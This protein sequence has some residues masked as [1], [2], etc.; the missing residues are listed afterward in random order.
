VRSPDADVP[1]LI[2]GG[3]PVGMVA[4]ILLAQQ[5]IANRVVERR[6]EPDGAPAAHVV[7]A[8]TFEILR[9]A[10]V[11]AAAIDAACKDPADAGFVRWVT[12]LAGDELGCLPF[13]R[14]SDAELAV[15][16]TPLRNLSQHR[17][18]PI[19]REHLLAQ[20]LASLASGQQ[21][22]SATQDAD[23]VT[24]QVRDLAS[25]ALRTIRSRWLLAA[26]GA[27]SRVREAAGI[28]IN[29][30][31]RLRSFVM[32]HFEAN[33]R[34][35]VRDRPA[36]LYWTTAPD[37]TGTFVAHDIDSTWVYM[38]V[39]DPD[40]EPAERYDE[41]LCAQIVRHA[42]GSD[43]F[44]F[45][46]RNIR[47]WHMS[48]QIAARYRDARIFLVGD[49]AHRFPPTGGL[50][51]NTGVQDAHNLAWKLAAVESGAAPPSLLD[52]YE[53]ERRPV[54]HT[55]AEA[56]ARNAMKMAEVWKALEATGDGAAAGVQVAIANQAEHFDMLGL[57]LGFCY[58]TGAIVPDGSVAP[59]VANPVREYVPSGRPGARLPHAWTQRNGARVSTL[60]L[61]PPGR[62]T[63]VAGAAGKPWIEAAAAITPA[64]HCIAIGSDVEDRG[65]AWSRELGIEADGALLVR[66]DQH[67]AWRSPRGAANRGDAL[68]AALAATLGT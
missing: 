30:P 61:L 36:V 21:W 67:V 8:R 14:Q 25:G 54:A 19:L 58:E 29:G 59:A 31:P 24:S 18:E 2:V 16:P 55:N 63:L 28:E 51:L 1:V 20:P 35:L 9:A 7:N 46:V 44:D 52:S 60:D 57:Q 40:T 34:D 43:A 23:G 39:M 47:T 11:P 49:A 10:G 37:A 65:G 64:P 68:R 48:L 17:L 6:S 53:A 66:P 38:H 26:D 5:G 56:S 22:E 50:G 3:G 45:R 32:I 13:E 27:G 33:L 62:F 4:S 12:T 41:A 42:L 15:T